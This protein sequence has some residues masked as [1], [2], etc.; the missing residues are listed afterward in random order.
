VLDTATLEETLDMLDQVEAAIRA[1]DEERLWHLTEYQRGDVLR[2]YPALSE[3]YLRRELETL[4]RHQRNVPDPVVPRD[5]SRHD[6]RVVADG[7]MLQCIGADWKS[8]VRLR[9]PG[10]GS[11]LQYPL[12]LSRLDSKLRIVR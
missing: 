3:V 7:R 10:T 6:F 5:R 4:L 1:F 12:F 11:E 8:S 2:A 9:N